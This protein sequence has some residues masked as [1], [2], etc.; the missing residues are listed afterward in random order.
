VIRY[1]AT[2]HGRLVTGALLALAGVLDLLV[3]AVSDWAGFGLVALGAVY[4]LTGLLG[5]RAETTAG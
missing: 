1:L 3:S 4:A 5:R 2:P